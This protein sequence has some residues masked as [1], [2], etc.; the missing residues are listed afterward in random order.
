MSLIRE[1]CLAVLM[2]GFTG[3]GINA[4]QVKSADVIVVGATPGGISAAISAARLGKSVFLLDR[5]AHIGGLPANGLGATDIA[6]PGV[7][8]GIFAE[9]T[10]RNYR[11][12]VE[13]YGAG[14]PQVEIC[15]KGYHFEPSVAEHTF[16][17]MLKEYP[18]ITVCT[19][20]QFDVAPENIRVHKGIVKEITVTNR[21]NGVI[22][23]YAGKNFIDATYEGDLAAAAGASFRTHRESQAAF[24]EPLA[25][26]VYIYWEAA[27]PGEGSTF[28]GD[29]AIQAYNYRLCLTDDTNNMVPV[30]CPPGYRREEFVSLIDDVKSGFLKG[31][32]HKASG[33][34]NPIALPNRKT[35]SNNHHGGLLS[36]DLPEE[37]WPWPTA[38][39]AWRD[40]FATRLKNYTLGLLW[41]CQHDTE[42]PQWFRDECLKYGFA[43]D[44][45]TDNENFPRQVY[46]REGRRI[47]GK[48]LFTGRDAL[49]VKPGERPPVHTSS[50]T[51][52]HY[53]IDSHGT[54]KREKNRVHLDGF[55]SVN[56]EP[57][58]VPIG[59]IIPRELGNVL[60]PVAVSSTHLGF[61][62]LRMEPCWMAMGQAAGVTAALA[63]DNN[64]AVG[65]TD[66][67]AI[68]RELLK[69]KAILYYYKDCDYTNPNFAA[70]QYFGLK[71]LIPGWYAH[72]YTLVTGKELKRWNEQLGLTHAPSIYKPG[73]TRRGELMQWYFDNPGSLKKVK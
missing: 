25:G 72:P 17:A 54:R 20:R 49:P 1:T 19:Q 22:E 6:T 11:Y 46:V 45:Y 42:L 32:M 27:E 40:S 14:S 18:A 44:E 23:K 60:T 2:L 51:A 16:T 48:Y 12:Y 35:D 53:A 39:W 26:K 65:N 30:T 36:T 31:F 37:N 29:S 50:I 34:V 56:T 15:N 67:D 70:L 59:V 64:K 21:T 61:G 58:T 41:F 9:F 38:D 66:I 55:L 10:E 5:N 28:E 7:T 33:I 13:R 47:E 52:S 24:N 69:Q 3:T 63:I 8:G 57:Y 71:G 43:K 62:T 73:I 68:Q 4:Q